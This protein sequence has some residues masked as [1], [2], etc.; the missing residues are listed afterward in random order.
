ME[1]SRSR[2][3]P[4]CH[5]CEQRSH[6]RAKLKAVSRKSTGN[7][8]GW[9]LRRSPN[10]KVAVGGVGIEAYRGF[11]EGVGMDPGNE[12]EG[13]HQLVDIVGCDLTVH[14]TQR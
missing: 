4:E 10:H 5:I 3:D 6:G 14:L 8:D 9:I 12:I 13:L 2:L 1:Q 11:M 7:D